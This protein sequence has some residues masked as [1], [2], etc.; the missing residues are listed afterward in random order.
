MDRHGNVSSIN[1]D[2]I[3]EPK[4]VKNRKIAYR[5]HGHAFLRGTPWETNFEDEFSSAD[6][7]A[8]KVVE[9]LLAI[10]PLGGTTAEFL[11]LLVKRP[12]N[13]REMCKFY[14]LDE[15]IHRS[16]LLLLLSLLIRSPARRYRYELYPAKFGLPPDGEIGKGNM[17]QQFHIAKKLCETSFLSNQYTVLIHASRKKFVFGDGCLD[18][19]TGSL[20]G[21]QIRGSA[22]VALTPR[23]C[24]YFCT[25]HTM[26][27]SP[28]CASFRAAP[29]MVDWIN[30]IVQIYARDRL[31]FLGRTPVLTD[32][33][34]RRRFQEHARKEDDL[35]DMLDEVAGNKIR[36]S[37]WNEF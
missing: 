8:S 35:I 22:L 12:K 17:Q 34:R 15:D 2:G 23:L 6:N 18:W 21:L 7:N 9:A 27:R 4:R 11:D 25:P 20:N 33:F 32:V 37:H 24:V 19:L 26:R 28:N 13:L 14:H 1:P 31:F 16:L 3:I 29:W 30:N 10:K 36:R 5:S